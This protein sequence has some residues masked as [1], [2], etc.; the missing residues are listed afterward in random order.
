MLAPPRDDAPAMTPAK[1]RLPVD[2]LVIACGVVAA[3]HVGKLPPALPWLRADLGLSLVEGGFLLSLVQ[4]AGVTLALGLGLGLVHLGL[5]RALIAGLALLGLV[6]ILGSFVRSTPWLLGAR[7]LEGVGF[8]MVS[9]AAPALLRR[10]VT[11]AQLNLRMGQ[12]GTYMPIGTALALLL[13]PWVMHSWGWPA[14]WIVLG[15]AAVAMAWLAWRRLGW[16]DSSDPGASN[17][18]PMTRTSS[19]QVPV[20]RQTLGAP[21]PW[22]LALTFACYSSQW[23]TVI[24][25]LPTVYADAGISPAWI[26]PLTALAALV[27]AL[28]NALAGRLLQAGHAPVHLLLTGFATM[29]LSAAAAF[30]LDG[31]WPAWVRYGAVLTFSAVGGLIPGTLFALVVRVAPDPR[32]SPAV[33]GWT[34]QCSAMGQFIGPPVAAWWTSHQ[35]AWS[36]TWVTTASAAMVGAMLAFTLHQTLKRPG[37]AIARSPA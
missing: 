12:W 16:E 4:A 10:L 9:L 32:A 8:L 36:Q 19:E 21:G 29:A 33:V 11:P 3:L 23:I 26:G 2:L 6:S 30:G 24:G 37:H 18:S 1:R 7:L 34:L 13:G 14:W 20:W 15:A 17:P 25:F 5:R 28:G 27:N 31:T 22:L 35:G